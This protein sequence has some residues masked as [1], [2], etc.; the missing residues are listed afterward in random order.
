[1]VGVYIAPMEVEL[2]RW[3]ADENRRLE[4]GE[5]HL[6]RLLL[7]EGGHAPPMCTDPLEDWIRLPADTA[8]VDARLADLGSIADRMGVLN[9]PRI[10]SDGVL[11]FRDKW[12]ALPPIEM[13]MVQAMLARAGNVVSR[14][15]LTRH[16]WQGAAAGRNVLDVHIARLR[17][18]IEPLGLSIRT[19]RQRGY[20]MEMP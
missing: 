3:P 18:R 16:G 4:L 1:M 17:R 6:P 15:A 2:V 7:V 10:D 9:P 12:V 14:D 19:V 8:D 20:A 11:R 13:R 5:K